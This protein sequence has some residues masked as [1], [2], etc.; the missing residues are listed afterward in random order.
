MTKSG[1]HVMAYVGDHVWAGADPMEQKVT[2]FTTPGE[3]NAYFSE[4]MNIMR[5]AVLE[6]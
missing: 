3:K 4:P 1:G 5:W 6:K 2:L